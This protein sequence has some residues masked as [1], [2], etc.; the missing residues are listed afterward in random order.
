[1]NG[2]FRLMHSHLWVVLLEVLVAA[3]SAHRWVLLDSPEAWAAAKAAAVTKGRAAEVICLVSAAEAGDHLNLA[4]HIFGPS[5]FLDFITSSDS[6][7]GALGL[8]GM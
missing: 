2:D 6:T 7:T 1:M 8:G 4:K 3:G 5:E